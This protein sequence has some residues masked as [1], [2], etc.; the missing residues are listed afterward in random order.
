MRI[1]VGQPERYFV[2]CTMY[3]ATILFTILPLTAV[4]AKTIL[5]DGTSMQYGVASDLLK[6]QSSGTFR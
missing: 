3:F 5:S 2:H 6:W 1:N 4:F